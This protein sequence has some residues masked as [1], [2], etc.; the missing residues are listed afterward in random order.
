MTRN[1][2]AIAAVA[3]ALLAAGTG[4]SSAEPFEPNPADNLKEVVAYGE[5][6]VPRWLADTITRAAQVTGVHA[7]YMLALADKESSFSHRVKAPTSSAVGLYQFLE[8]TWLEVLNE[9]AAKHGFTAAADAITV[10][11]GR[12]TVTDSENRRWIL[13]LREDPYL[14]AL[15]A[16]ELVKK[17][18]DRL[19]QERD[20]KV[21]K[22]ELYLA[23]LLGSAGASRLLKL[24]DER[25]QESA[26]KAFQ[27]AAKA[28][29]SVFYAGVDKRK[30]ATVAEVH[31][32]ITEMIESRVTRYA[33]AKEQP[34]SGLR[35]SSADPMQSVHGGVGAP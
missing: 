17:T 12:P 35:L 18:Q 1:T 27:A 10:I 21:T 14:S 22:G 16:G 4:L 30:A 31:A 9:H 25:P 32:R 8:G 20:G 13:S 11:A 19:A 3:A 2:M 6:R 23:H 28:N 29:K 24:V 34:R 7:T 15:M 33:G 5:T 26:A